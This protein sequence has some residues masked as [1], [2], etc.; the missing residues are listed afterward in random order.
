[1]LSPVR[2]ALLSTSFVLA[3]LAPR[4]SDAA[5]LPFPGSAG[6]DVGSG[7]PAQFETSGLCWHDRLQCLFAVSDDGRV[8]RVEADGSLPQSWS[9]GNLDL[10][11][12]TVADPDSDFVYLGI[13]QPDSIAEFRLSTGSITRTFAFGAWMSPLS[14]DGVEG[15]T[16]VPD[17]NAAEGGEFWVAQ[18]LD[19]RIFR[20]R[21]PIASSSTSTTPI[22]LGSFVPVPGRV[23]LSGLAFDPVADC[24]VAIW[25]GANVIA[26]ISR[27]GAVLTEWQLPGN[28]QEGVAVRG[29][30]LFVGYDSSF[31]I[32]KHDAF[33]TRAACSAISADQARVSLANG[34]V[35]QFALHATQGIPSGAAY[36][37]IGS[38]SGTT[39][40]LPGPGFTIPLQPDGY[41]AL[42]LQ[43]LNAGPFVGTS[44]QISAN[45]GVGPAFA[46]IV[47]P[48]GLPP[49][50]AGITVHHALLAA[51]PSTLALVA[52]SD[53]VALTFVP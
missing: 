32:W 4:G 53:A 50:F 7:L 29:C 31:T 30:E 19:G 46:Q 44:G 39:P 28:D 21:L 51:D 8:V 13:E 11:D 43:S 27:A 48:A 35:V 24:V 49:A 25:D 9:L 16:F 45:A 3:L 38:A 20:F 47:V 40:G 1:M 17:E 6:A 42:T 14:S 10:E 52:A 2:S 5:I 15:I 36:A 41:F 26:R 23:D 18:Q 37:L 22:F 12:I 34:G 33:P